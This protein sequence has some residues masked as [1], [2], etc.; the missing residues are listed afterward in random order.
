MKMEDGKNI[1]Q[2]AGIREFC[3][4]FAIRPLNLARPH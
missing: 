2:Q 3:T 4:A 1:L